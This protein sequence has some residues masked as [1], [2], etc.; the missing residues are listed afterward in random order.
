M[1]TEKVWVPLRKRCEPRPAPKLSKAALGRIAT[2]LEK[3]ANAL[4]ETK[5]RELRRR[6]FRH[7]YTTAIEC[8]E[9]GASLEDA[10]GLSFYDAES[11]AK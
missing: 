9:E 2:A 3:I 11:V 8:W 1:K 4:D 6:A 7:G 5:Q 10:K